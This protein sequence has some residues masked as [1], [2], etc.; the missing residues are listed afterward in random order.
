MDHVPV[1][2]EELLLRSLFKRGRPYAVVLPDP[3]R[4]RTR[5]SLPSRERGIDLD[6][7]RVGYI[8]PSLATALVSLLIWG[9][10]TGENDMKR[11][12]TQLDFLQ[13]YLSKP[14]SKLANVFSVSR[15]LAPLA[16]LPSM[17]FKSPPFIAL[18]VARLQ[19]E[20]LRGFLA[21]A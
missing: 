1:V 8:Y 10:Y 9:G 20:I 17:G 14:K 4:A 18:Q 6:C 13:T 12:R 3:V 7:T 11:T 16:S 2:L 5:R 19:F 15:M 21:V